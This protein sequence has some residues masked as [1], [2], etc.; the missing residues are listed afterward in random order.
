MIVIFVLAGVAAVVMLTLAPFL[1]PWPSRIRWTIAVSTVPDPWGFA[2]TPWPGLEEMTLQTVIPCPDGLMVVGLWAHGPG[3]RIRCGYQTP[4]A[5]PRLNSRGG[6]R[7]PR[8]SCRWS[9][10]MAKSPCTDRLRRFP[11]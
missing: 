2:T 5:G 10:R 8:P 7:P 6:L 1:L 4:R 9:R 3:F 11:A